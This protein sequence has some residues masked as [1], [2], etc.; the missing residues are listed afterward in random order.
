MKSDGK[1]K[2]MTE[3]DYIETYINRFMNKQE[4]KGLPYGIQ[5]MN[6]LDHA[7]EQAEEAW[8]RYIAK[9]SKQSTI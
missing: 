5:Y 9:K 2:E 6:Y 7:Y 8:K 3:A 4:H 1:K